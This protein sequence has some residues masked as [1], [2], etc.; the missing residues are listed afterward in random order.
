MCFS[1]LDITAMFLKHNFCSSASGDLRSHITVLIR[2]CSN[3]LN[4]LIDNIAKVLKA[5]QNNEVGH[6]KRT[7]IDYQDFLSN[8]SSRYDRT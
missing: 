1:F 4:R 3:T 6:L 5:H 7:R 2:N 8:T